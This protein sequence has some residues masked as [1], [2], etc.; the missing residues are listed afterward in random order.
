MFQGG[1]QRVAA[2]GV[3]LERVERLG[4]QAAGDDLA[5]LVELLDAGESCGSVFPMAAVAA[6]VGRHEG[7]WVRRVRCVR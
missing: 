2:T 7:V 3:R 6:W 4:A 5:G 1:G